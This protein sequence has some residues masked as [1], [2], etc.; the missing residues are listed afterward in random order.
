M[1]TAA[2]TASVFDQFLVDCQLKKTVDV[3]DLAFELVTSGRLS[4]GYRQTAVLHQ[5]KKDLRKRLRRMKD[6]T[7]FPV[8]H[9]I[10]EDDPES[11]VAVSRYKQLQFFDR[12]DYVR[13]WRYWDRVE[14]KAAWMKSELERRFGKAFENEELTQR[15]L[16]NTDEFEP[17]VLRASKFNPPNRPR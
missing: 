14:D 11:G 7:G 17:A 8:W 12:E 10:T 15:T 16:F 3:D 13:V 6:A 1:T 4:V 5:V 2:Q 9:S